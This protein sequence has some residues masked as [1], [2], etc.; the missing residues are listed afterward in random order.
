MLRVDHPD[1]LADPAGYLERLRDGGAER[2]WVEK[3]LEPDEQLRDW[4]VT[5]TVG[6]EFLNDVCG[7]V[8]RPGR[9]GRPDR[10]LP[11]A[12]RRPAAVRASSPPRRSSSRRPGLQAR[13][14]AAA[15]DRRGPDLEQSLASLPIYRTYVEPRLRRR[16]RAS[17]TRADREAR[18]RRSRA[19]HARESPLRLA[20]RRRAGRVRHPLP[21]DDAGDQAKGVE[22][23]AFYRYVRLLA[24]NEVGGDPGRFGISVAD[25]HARQ[26]R[27]GPA[28]S[29]QNLLITQTHDTKRSGDSRARIGALPG[30]RRVA[31]RGG[32]WFE[33]AA[34]L[35]TRS[36]G[37]RSR[38]QAR[39]T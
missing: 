2:V 36:T 6:Y 8:R 32:R 1:G 9:R 24:L 28:A 25:F 34:P 39:S 19:R 38:R 27:A 17:S 20:R 31:R 37:G 7:A 29:P 26:R 14:R 16:G 11:G 13:D 30:R 22:D 10:A 4:P 23:T 15:P 5:G 18:R 33:L 3:I 21:A 12:H 35:R